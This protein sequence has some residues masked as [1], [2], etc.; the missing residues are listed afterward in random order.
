M[1]VVDNADKMNEENEVRKK[2]SVLD[3]N[4]KI[5]IR[6]QLKM[7]F[8]LKRAVTV[9]DPSASENPKYINY[10]NTYER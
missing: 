7:Y 8:L 3:Y 5:S 1:V 2:T 9:N 4:Y 6:N 10:E